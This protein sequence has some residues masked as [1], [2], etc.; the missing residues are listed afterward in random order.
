MQ[1]VF[2]GLGGGITPKGSWREGAEAGLGPAGIW[3][4]MLS[5]RLSSGAGIA[6]SRSFLCGERHWTFSFHVNQ[7]LSRG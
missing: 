1:D 6:P 5:Q 4:V 2:L 3:A 7:S